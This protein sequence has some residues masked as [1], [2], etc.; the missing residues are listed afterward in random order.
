MEDYLSN[1]PT[2]VIPRSS[3]GYETNNKYRKFPPLMTDGRSIISSLNNENQIHKMLLSKNGISSNWQYR[4]YLMDNANTIMEYNYREAAN[5]TGYSIL[6][7]KKTSSNNF[8]DTYD[9]LDQLQSSDLKEMYLT[10]EQLYAKKM[11]RY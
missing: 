9:F 10:R 4:K 7:R 2:L 11:R 6:P 5:D 1:A 3:L 8:L